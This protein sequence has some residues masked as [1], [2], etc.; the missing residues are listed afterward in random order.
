MKLCIKLTL[1]MCSSKTLLL[2]VAVVRF[3]HSPEALEEYLH[4]H[5]KLALTV[6]FICEKNNNKIKIN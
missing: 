6:I 3:V 5:T 4:S 2:P 1:A